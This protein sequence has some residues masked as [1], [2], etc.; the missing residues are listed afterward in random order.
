MNTPSHSPFSRPRSRA[1]LIASLTE[2]LTPVAPVKPRNGALSIAAAT[3]V[4]GIVSMLY[5]GFWTGMISGEASGYF[6][7]TNGLLAVLGAAST[8]AVASSALP[9]VGARSNAA[10]WGAA[11]IGVLPV[12]GLLSV[13][14]T[15]TARRADPVMWYWECA[16]YGTIAGLLIA[17]AAI[18]FL[19]RGAPV[20]LERA[21]WMTGIAAGSL[22]S[23]AYGITC[24]VDTVSH[25]GIVHIAPVAIS[26]V[27]GRLVVPRLIRW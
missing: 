20:S 9:R 6:W 11:M 10:I 21:G 5:F 17:G 22:G 23:L 27:I 8:A 24:P 15:M 19:R 2:N 7:I 3:L 16:A 12:A 4:A 14:S 13:I 25:V 18:A 1:D 26:A